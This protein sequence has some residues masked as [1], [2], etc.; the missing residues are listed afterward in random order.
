MEI[1]VFFIELDLVHQIIS[2]GLDRG[3]YKK[4]RGKRGI[5]SHIII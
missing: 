1:K 5:Q 2:D 3:D 4:D